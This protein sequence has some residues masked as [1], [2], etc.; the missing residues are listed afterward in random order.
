MKSFFITGVSSGLGL[1]LCRQLLARGDSVYGI[2]RKEPPPQEYSDEGSCGGFIWQPCDVTKFEDIHR[3]IEHQRS[4]GFY[5][6][7]V[8]LNSGAHFNER[9]D[10]AYEDYERLF[11]VNCAGALGW[12]EAYL[13]EFK[14]RESGQFVYIS[15]LAASFPFPFRGAYSAS[16]AYTSLAFKC[17]Q[18]QFARFG[19]GFTVIYAG[20]LDTKMSSRVKIPGFFKYPVSRAAEVVLQAVESGAGCKYFPLRTVFLEWF[21]TLLPS[22]A[23]F[24]LLG[25]KL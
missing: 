5:P 17:L 6:D 21:L 20:L 10:F 22:S 19:V 2:S 3:I 25:K 16:K 23:L 12:V 8:I 9:D 4:I 15:S 1:E 11:K 24:R 14:N 13:P 18:K 7:V